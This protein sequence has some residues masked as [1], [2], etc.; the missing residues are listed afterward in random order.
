M[1]V[2]VRPIV[3]LSPP[4]GGAPPTLTAYSKTN[5]AT[6]YSNGNAIAV[7]ASFTWAA[8]DVIVAM[9]IAAAGNSAGPHNFVTIDAETNITWTSNG[10]V[11]ATDDFNCSAQSWTGVATGA[12]SGTISGVVTVAVSTQ[13]SLQAWHFTATAGV[14]NQTAAA[15]TGTTPTQALTASAN[16]A[17]VTA[18]GDWNAVAT[19][20]TGE[21]NTGTFTERDDTNDPGAYTVWGGDWIG[22]SAGADN[23]G[24]TSGA[25]RQITFA[26]TVEVLGT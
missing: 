3:F 21:T 26:G 16:S 11:G 24:T 17:V 19:D 8:G 22:V 10:S 13:F 6:T 23:W 2:L 7:A 14:G 4:A 12:G 1:G 15:Q 18:W 25:G 5:A 20:S 9:A